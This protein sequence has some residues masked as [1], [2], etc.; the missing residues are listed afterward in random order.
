MNRKINAPYLLNRRS[1]LANTATGL[2][3]IGLA[4]LL[5][6]QN[7]LLAADDTSPIRPEIDPQH[8]SR[9]RDPH[10]AAAAKN[11]VMIFC[12]GCLQSRRHVRLQT[13]TDSDARQTDAG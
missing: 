10:F 8:P 4:H 6:S 11:V 9:V 7:R 13:G 2:S 12:A 1:F 5:A 3:S